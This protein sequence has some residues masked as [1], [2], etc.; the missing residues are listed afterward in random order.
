MIKRLLKALKDG[1]IK[2]PVPKEIIATARQNSEQGHPLVTLYNLSYASLYFLARIWAGLS[3][4]P[5]EGADTKEP[6]REPF[7]GLKGSRQHKSNGTDE[8]RGIDWPTAMDLF[9]NEAPNLLG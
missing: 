3:I 7:S 4:M 2:H 6:Q 5:A 8:E 9:M 1:G